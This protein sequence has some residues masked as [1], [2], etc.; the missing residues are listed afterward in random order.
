MKVSAVLVT[1]VLVTAALAGCGVSATYVGA[2]PGKFVGY[3]RR[4]G[5][6]LDPGSDSAT[7]EI[8]DSDPANPAGTQFVSAKCPYTKLE[9]GDTV[10]V[11]QTDYSDSWTVVGVDSPADDFKPSVEATTL[12]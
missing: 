2:Q 1:L 3:E 6:S 7:I 4:L 11:K 12:Y 9:I 8:A 5:Y 10:T